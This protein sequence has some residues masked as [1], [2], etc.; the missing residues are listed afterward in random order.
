MEW[1][2]SPKK[3]GS[4]VCS[5]CWA[6]AQQVQVRQNPEHLLADV[7]SWASCISGSTCFWIGSP[8]ANLWNLVMRE[9]SLLCNFP[10]PGCLRNKMQGFV[11]LPRLLE[12]AL[13]ILQSL[14]KAGKAARSSMNLLEYPRLHF[15]SA[16][17]SLDPSLSLKQLCFG[18]NYSY[19]KLWTRVKCKEGGRQHPTSYHSRKHG[20]DGKEGKVVS[21]CFSSGMPG[22]AVMSCLVWVVFLCLLSPSWWAHGL[23]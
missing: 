5:R 8:V 12:G 22:P 14:P 17:C 1:N 7:F 9:P 21:H 11:D 16:I 10:Y 6:E 2:V 23:G 15:M 13:L 19:C 18:E 20:R 4:A 3:A